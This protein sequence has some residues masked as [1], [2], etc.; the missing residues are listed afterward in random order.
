MRIL[1]V[2]LSYIYGNDEEQAAK[3]LAR[4][5]QLKSIGYSVIREDG[6]SA[7][8]GGIIALSEGQ[9]VDARLAGISCEIEGAVEVERHTA[10]DSL[11]AVME[12]IDRFAKVASNAAFNEKVEV[13][14][15]GMGLMLFNRVMLLSDACSDA[16]QHEM[17]NGW[18]II[19]ACPQPDQRRPDYILGRYAPEYVESS[20]AGNSASRGN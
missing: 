12:K 11:D 9:Y 4:A 17:D 7:L 20:G 18:R 19:A 15:P 14:T 5:E 8:D 1:T 10:I 6:K 2:R 3:K 16:L 13:Y